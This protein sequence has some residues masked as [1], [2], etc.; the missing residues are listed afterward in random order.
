MNK[1]RDKKEDIATD[2]NEVQRVIRPYLKK[3]T[4]KTIVLTGFGST[5]T[6]V[7]REEGRGASLEEMSP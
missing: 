2:I 6:R 3:K 7:I 1:I 5:Q 4:T